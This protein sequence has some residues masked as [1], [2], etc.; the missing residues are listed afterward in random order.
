MSSVGIRQVMWHGH[1][2]CSI[3]SAKDNYR[4]SLDGNDKMTKL[5][6]F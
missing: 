1:F 5:E 2:F 3:G 4:W 6:E